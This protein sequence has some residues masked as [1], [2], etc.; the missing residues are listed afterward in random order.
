MSDEWIEINESSDAWDEKEAVQ[1]I[2]KSSKM[3]V[4]PNKSNMYMLETTDGLK[5][6]WG[7]TVLNTKFEQIPVGAEVRVEY[8]GKAKGKT[9]TEYKNY[10]VQYKNT[11][12]STVASEFGGAELL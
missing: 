10:K 2:Y 7:S 4:G 9:G 1:G 11:A 8:L 6:V 5:G 12:T 3:N